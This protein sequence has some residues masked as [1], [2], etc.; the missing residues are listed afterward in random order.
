[1]L[2]KG[3]IL[4]DEMGLGKTVEMLA[5]ILAHKWPGEDREHSYS[6]LPKEV[7]DSDQQPASSPSKQP[8]VCIRS[9][10]KVYQS[11]VKD[12]G[13]SGPHDMVKCLC[14]ATS[15]GNYQGEFVQ[16]E[17]CLV[18][19]HSK[20]AD[21]HTSRHDTFVCIKCLLDK[22][23]T[24]NKVNCTVLC[25]LV[26]VCCTVPSLLPPSSLPIPP[27]PPLLPPLSPFQSL[28]S[29]L[30]SLLL[31]PFLL[32]LSSPVPFLPLYPPLLP[33]HLSLSQPSTCLSQP[34][35][36]GATL[37]ISPTSIAQQ[38]ED[39]IRKHTQPGALK[40]LVSEPRIGSF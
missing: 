9:P 22:V 18:W 10:S 34:L 21:F 23:S 36:A 14:G 7:A 40:V 31:F 6:S 15:E 5:L 27:P 32:P 25:I 3:G 13:S 4:A 28:Y 8:P 37:I 17:R 39:E 24:C 11:P 16:C 26:G 12:V 19:Q 30:L 35:P 20:C 2:P 1:M 29:P 38:W 33:S